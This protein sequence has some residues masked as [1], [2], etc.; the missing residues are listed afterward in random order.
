MESEPLFIWWK[1]E[2]VGELVNSIVDMGYVE[3]K[4]IPAETQHG[5]NFCKKAIQL[6]ANDVIRNSSLGFRIKIGIDSRGAPSMHGYVLSLSDDQLFYRMVSTKE[7]IEMLLSK[8]P[9]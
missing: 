3:G 9:E 2:Y 4:W 8:V 1:E 7:G 6:N 5:A